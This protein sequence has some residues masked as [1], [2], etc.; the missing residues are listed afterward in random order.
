MQ[1]W[2]FM[3]DSVL[4]KISSVQDMDKFV[5]NSTQ[6]SKW[7]FRRKFP[8]VQVSS[9]NTIYLESYHKVRT[10]IML[11]RRKPK[12]QHEVLTI[13]KLDKTEAQLNI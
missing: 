5:V 8:G 2:I 9:I 12:N 7:K 10:T 3:S 11:T 4:C 1:V 6:M 13:E